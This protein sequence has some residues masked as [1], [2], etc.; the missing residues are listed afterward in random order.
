MNKKIIKPKNKCTIGWRANR[1][2]R[3][4]VMN[5]QNGYT[6]D[7][8]ADY[9]KPPR[10]PLTRAARGSTYVRFMLCWALELITH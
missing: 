8:P 7:S 10:V 3:R 6:K 1:L 4:F 2:M 9:F 5:V